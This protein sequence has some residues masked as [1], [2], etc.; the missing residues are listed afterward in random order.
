MD[1][2]SAEKFSTAWFEYW[3]VLSSWVHWLGWLVSVSFWCVLLIEAVCAIAA[4]FGPDEVPMIVPKMMGP[5]I[6]RCLLSLL[7]LDLVSQ[8]SSR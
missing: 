8:V 2:I 6:A 1:S 4:R 7:L 3:M 5:G